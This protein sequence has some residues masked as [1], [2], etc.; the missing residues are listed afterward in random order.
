[1]THDES[2]KITGRITA[3]L[4]RAIQAISN[5]ATEKQN[6][7]LDA[8]EQHAIRILRSRQR[9]IWHEHDAIW[10]PDPKVRM[11]AALAFQLKDNG[12]LLT[13]ANIQHRRGSLE[14]SGCDFVYMGASKEPMCG[15]CAYCSIGVMHVRTLHGP[16]AYDHAQGQLILKPGKTVRW[17]MCDEC[18]ASAITPVELEEVEQ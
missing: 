11:R 1:M 5:F 4:E 3:F 16:M 17:R 15:V 13:Y 10:D 14:C 18:G 2:L 9:R 6:R 7:P 8:D 12:D